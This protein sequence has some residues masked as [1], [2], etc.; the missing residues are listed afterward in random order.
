MHISGV[1][2][3][4][5]PRQAKALPL[6]VDSPHSGRQYPS[7]FGF[8]C[9]RE[10][11]QVYEDRFVD[12]LISNL[13]HLGATVVQAEAPRSYLDLNRAVD[14]IDPRQLES[15][16]HGPFK[17]RPSVNCDRGTGL[18][19]THA[20]D[21]RIYDAPLKPEA[22]MA[23]IERYYW[24]YYEAMER[25]AV[26][27]RARFGRV[28]HLNMHSMPPHTNNGAFDIVLGDL[29]GQSCHPD[30]LAVVQARFEAHGLRVTQN[31][32]YKGAQLTRTFGL[33]A[34][35]SESLQ[36]EISKG[37]YMKPDLV[38]LDRDKYVKLQRAIEDVVKA[39]GEFTK[40]YLSNTSANEALSAESRSA[41]GTSLPKAAKDVTP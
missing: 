17:L 9:P 6:L 35:G 7:D 26:N 36:I 31:R 23:R 40:A 1:L 11:L 3:V 25:E 2:R 22:V 18:I 41:I 27:L 34:K 20:G 30:F 32:P 8:H 14:D 15:A 10:A 33:P 13:A 37:L 16:W 29:D 12:L 38:T 21:R 4:F 5:H 24:P 28:W 19:W 39:A